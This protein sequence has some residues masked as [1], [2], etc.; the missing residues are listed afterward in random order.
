MARSKGSANLSASLEVLAGAPLD[1]RDIVQTKADLTAQDSFPYKYIG[2]EVYVVAENKKYRLIGNDPT[3]IANWQEVG[4]GGGGGTSD[5]TDLSNK[6]S[7]ENVTLSGNKSASELGLA[8]TTDLADFITKTV[9][10]LV[11]YYKKTETY[12][13][14]EVDAIATAIKN[15]RFEVVATL[16][17]SNIKTNVIYLVPKAESE[18]GDIK[19]EYI[20]LNGTTAGWERIGSTD[21]DL[22]GYVT[23]TALNTALANYT[24][25][26][27]L[28]ALLAGKQD[29][30]Q[31]STLPTPSAELEGKIFEY[32]GAT[33][34]GLTHGYFYE[35][36]SDGEDP[37]TY[38]WVQTNVQ[39]SGGGG[40]S[41]TAGDGIEITN[42][43]ISTKQSEEGDIDEIVDVYPTA[44]NLVSIANAFNR[45]DIYSTDERM[46]GQWIDGKPL[47]QA[48]VGNDT[49]ASNNLNV[50]LNSSSE[51]PR[52]IYTKT[53]TDDA[54]IKMFSIKVTTNCSN[55]DGY[56]VI[57][58]NSTVVFKLHAITGTETVYDGSVCF[59]IS[60]G[61]TLTVE[62]DWDGSHTS[63]NWK[64]FATC[65]EY[66]IAN[67]DYCFE[68]VQNVF[69]YTKTTDTA[70]SIGNAYEYSTDEK[71]V[72]TWISGE[73]LYQ[74]TVATGGEVP[75]GAT[76]I[77]RETQTGYDTIKYIKT[78]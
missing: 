43:V 55:S 78:T 45:G 59:G 5:Y 41:Y 64:F 73:L 36:V 19:D 68:K 3:A 18:S 32:T 22:S 62:G 23:T 61:D 15:S 27:D 74:K 9:D 47:Y 38:S 24:T 50:N 7:I 11:N 70:I 48:Y 67:V 34:G 1:A 26:T 37:A 6:P 39:P 52:T 72:G 63:I 76:L 28:T 56:I 21:I 8:K 30:V 35:C 14:G 51:H 60:S 58:K 31:Y 33:G 66:D 49:Y 20:N 46:V 53:Y 40:S 2:M 65:Y 42:D 16:P 44:G 71:V 57:K 54:L 10:D 25:T 69:N 13:K 77:Q 75:S 17:T 29:K 12:T 4:T